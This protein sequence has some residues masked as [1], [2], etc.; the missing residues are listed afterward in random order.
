MPAI[1]EQQ[2]QSATCA[3]KP[4]LEQKEVHAVMFQR[5]G[6]LRG[7]R[8]LPA[9]R[10]LLATSGESVAVGALSQWAQPESRLSNLRGDLRAPAAD[11]P[12]LL[13]QRGLLPPGAWLAP[14]TGDRPAQAPR[15][16]LRECQY[17]PVVFR[18]HQREAV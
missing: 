17:L 11:L 2:S 16:L 12:R 15:H 1:A 5:R 6:F 3:E 7:F 14:T 10:R 9:D 4:I 18:L 13:F 8:R